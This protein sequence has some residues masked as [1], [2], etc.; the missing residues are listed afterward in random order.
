MEK[1]VEPFSISGGRLQFAGDAEFFMKRPLALFDAF[2]LAQAA[3]VPFGH[4]LG[5]SIWQSLS[6]IGPAFRASA[7]TASAFLKLLRRRGRA[8]YVLRLM[9]EVGFLA[10]LLPE[11]GRVTLLVQHDL[12]HQYT[13][14]EH[15]LR[16][17]EALDE[18]HTGRDQQ[19]AH[20]R[21]IFDEVEDPALLYLS[22]LLHDIGKGRGSGHVARGVKI[23]ERTC[24]RLHLK[25]RA[26]AKVLLLVQQHV[27]MAQ[28][29]QRRDLNEAQVV[30]DFTAQ[31][32]TLDALNMLLLLTYADLNAVAPGVTT[33]IR[34]KLCIMVASTFFLRTSPP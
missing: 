5:N 24:R 30:A 9:H 21:I 31:M 7:E 18:L 19:R 25:E 33:A 3:R 17:V 15:T 32:E 29:A 26:A 6:A 22:L 4:H 16:A 2:A 8:G 27:A 14:D 12:Y 20:L 10:R 11:F 13:V 23:A 28:L 34:I 1:A